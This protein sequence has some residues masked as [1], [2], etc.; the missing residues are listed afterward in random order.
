MHLSLNGMI[1]PT[2][3]VL[4]R[5]SNYQ[6]TE[7]KNEFASAQTVAVWSKTLLTMCLVAAILA[8]AF[9]VFTVLVGVTRPLLVTTGVMTRLAGNDLTVTIE[10]TERRDEIGAMA[11]AV[12]VFKD[13]MI[14]KREAD[15]AGA[16]ENAAKMRRA[17]ALDALTQQFEAQ[18][19]ALTQGLSAASNEME[20]TARS[21]NDTATATTGHSVSVA[22][23]AEQASANVQTVAAA[24]EEMAS[25]IHEIAGQVTRSSAIAER[26]ASD[27]QRTDA[28]IRKLSSSAE[29]I[30]D[31]VALITNIAGQT[32][33]LALNATIEAARAGEAGRGFAVVAGEVKMLAGQ[34]AKATE[35]IAGH[36]SAVQGETREA[37]EAIQAIGRTIAELRTI[38]MSV[39]A[40]MEEQGAA[41]QE[42][43]RNVTQA[44]QGTHSVTVSIVQ[45]KDGA[46]STGAASA[47]VLG[48]AQELAQHASR[49]DAEVTRF[50]AAV[51]AA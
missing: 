41:T 6:L 12:Q 26:A 5:L 25:S 32:N 45:V 34:T 9:G 17:Q 23:A 27:A 8:S 28:M 50:L 42:I 24:S 29:R 19:S 46:G 47:Q 43:V 51:R 14:A 18:V 49:L 2:N 10:G 39:A 13:A 4:T 35:T 38:S 48:A 22:S 21:M 37:V 16:I 33:L 7:T 20:V 30:G 36:I 11:R 1:Q 31:V 40:A 15:E 3:E 44:A